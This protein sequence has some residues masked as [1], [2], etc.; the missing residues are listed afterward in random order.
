LHHLYFKYRFKQTFNLKQT[1]ELQ[2][3]KE[4]NMHKSMTGLLSFILIQSTSFAAT[5]TTKISIDESFIINSIKKNPPT[6]KQIEAQFLSASSNE[7]AALDKYQYQLEGAANY[8]KTKEFSLSSFQ[9]VTSPTNSASLGVTKATQKGM[10][11]GLKTF[12]EQYTN[13][14]V[15]KG[16]TTGFAVTASIDLY[17]DFLGKLSSNQIEALSYASQKAELEKNIQ[18]KAFTIS[19]RKLYWSLVANQEAIN[20]SKTLLISAEKQVKDAQRRFKNNIADSGEVA[21]YKSQVAAKKASIISFQYQREDLI[22]Q[23][24][25]LLPSISENEIA[26]SK[27]SLDSTV[28]E[29]LACAARIQSEAHVPMTFTYYDEILDKVK[30]QYN[31]QK[32]VTNSYSDWD[33]NLSSEYKK[34]G[35]AVDSYSNAYDNYSDDGRSSV[36]LGLAITIPLGSHKKTTEDVMKIVD[37]KRFVAQQEEIVGKLNAYHTQVVRSVALLQEIVK[38]Q[39]ENSFYLAKSLK[40][41]K[42]K[43]NQARISV[44]QLVTDQDALLQSNLNEINTKLSVITTLLDYLSVYTETPCKLNK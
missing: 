34:V 31:S 4:E 39:Q 19:L 29:V 27:Y 13:T 18:V 25:E 9:P 16:S 10:K 36:A 32:I 24:K 22:K 20:I 8:T 33:I 17:R 38:N 11:F 30:K 26:L 42:R 35:K 28:Q 15:N 37:E 1:F 12:N 6:V 14:Y 7:K 43:Y 40:V 44:S 21:R 2:N 3:N 23:L 5:G 41:A